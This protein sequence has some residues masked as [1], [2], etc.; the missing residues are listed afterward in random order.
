[1]AET[2]VFADSEHSPPRFE[3]DQSADYSQ[4][5]LY[6]KSEI[7]AVLRS[8]IQKGSLITVYFDQGRSFLLTSMIALTN[9]NRE[10]I[11]DIGSNEEMNAKALLADKLIFHDH[12]RQGE[13]S[14]QPDPLVVNEV[15]GDSPFLATSPRLFSAC[16]AASSFSWQRRLP[17][18]SLS[19]PRSGV[20]TAV[21]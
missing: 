3:L 18:R 21:R 5:L 17:G 9:E 14:I 12:H 8:L 1:M 10:F 19:A 20:P 15:A 11:L 16:N 6:S 4:F 13:G 7:L 2:E